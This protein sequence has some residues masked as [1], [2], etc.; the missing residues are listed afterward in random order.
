MIRSAFVLSAT[1][2]FACACTSEPAA[3]PIVCA[4]PADVTASADVTITARDAALLPRPDTPFIAWTYDGDVPGPVLRMTVGETRTVMLVNQSPRAASIHFHGMSYAPRDD[5]T[6]DA[7]ESV[8]QPGCAHVYTI[9]ARTP[10][11]WP[12]HGHLATRAELAHGQYGAI[13]VAAPDEVAADR[14][15]VLFMGQL[16]LDA[17]GESGEAEAEEEQE[18][19]GPDRAGAES[20]FMTF[21]GHAAGGDPRAIVLQDG[22]YQLLAGAQEQARVGDRVRWRVVNLSPDELHTFGIHGHGFCDRGGL[23]DGD[24]TCPDGG[25][26][27]NIVDISP[28]KGVSFE[29]HEAMSGTWM[30]HCHII[31]H[32]DEGMV[33][34]YRVTP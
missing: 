12:Y 14:E 10:G 27:I 7:P 4:T 31:D 23:A 15:F 2:A 5:G 18:E 11:V 19:A 21:N 6:A 32:A 8:V 22:R 30:Y 28:L 16:G 29:L 3:Q 26:I 1:C 13:V 34:Y 9:T 33:G 24:G 20:L 17:E 25:H